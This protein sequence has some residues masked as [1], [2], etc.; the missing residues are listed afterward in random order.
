MKKKC[1]TNKVAP[2]LNNTK[3]TKINVKTI[4]CDN[5][6]KNNNLEENCAKMFKEIKFYFT[7][8]GTPQ[9]NGV[10]EWG[11]ATLYSGMRVMMSHV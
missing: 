1:Y 9:E 7:S 3:T 5:S 11:F 2:L 10:V 6:V 4:C 8:P